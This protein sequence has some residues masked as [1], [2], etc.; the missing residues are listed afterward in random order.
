MAAAEVAA[1]GDDVMKHAIEYIGLRVTVTKSPSKERIGISGVVV[2]ETKNTFIIEKDDGKEVTIPKQ[3]S[4][5]RF[6]ESG[7]AFDVEGSDIAF[8]PEDRPKKAR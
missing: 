1:E 7:K 3:N 6:K 5:F 2:D 8:R 4:S